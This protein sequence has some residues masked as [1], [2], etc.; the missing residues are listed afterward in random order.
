[1]S[2]PTFTHASIIQQAVHAKI[3]VFSEKPIGESATE[4][5]HLIDMANDAKI[6][7]C[8]GFQ[9][10]FDPSYQSAVNAIRQGDIGTPLVVTIFFG[11]HPIP[12]QQFM[13][14]G[15]DIFLDLCA[16]DVDFITHA[17]QDHVVSVYA[18]GIPNN[19]TSSGNH[20]D[21]KDNAIMVMKL[22]RGTVVTLFMSRSA[23]YGYDQRMEIFGTLGM[24]TVQNQPETSTVVATAQGIRHD[25]WKHSFPER[26]AQ[27]FAM[28]LDAFADV[29]LVKDNNID[30]NNKA[31][32]VWPITGDQCVQVQRVADAA[33]QSCLEGR[34]VELSSPSWL[35]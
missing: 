17:L 29:L 25:K 30:N 12:P 31:A 4:I 35:Q 27:A 26:F 3:G 6:P 19:S 9:R 24:V 2:S 11:D 23:T 5:Q 7:L 28:E 10:R 8:C 1:M 13:Q 20:H 18:T 16:H 22:S 14:Q 33:R 34:V 21:N 15:G 32:L